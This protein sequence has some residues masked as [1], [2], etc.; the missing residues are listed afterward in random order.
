MLKPYRHIPRTMA[1]L[2]ASRLVTAGVF[3]PA[4]AFRPV[5]PRATLSM[6]CRPS[7]SSSFLG[8]ETRAQSMRL[9]TKIT[10]PS[11]AFR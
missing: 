4:A 3:R 8:G 10:S 9:T 11:F 7:T 6:V 5:A 1:S 2:M